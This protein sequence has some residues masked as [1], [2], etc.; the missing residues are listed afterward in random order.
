VH[1]TIYAT[2]FANKSALLEGIDF[3]KHKVEKYI[4]LFTIPVS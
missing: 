2:N 3:V 1:L 4:I